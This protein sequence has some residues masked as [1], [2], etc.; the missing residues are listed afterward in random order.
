MQSCF[1]FCFYFSDK[2]EHTPREV[3][4]ASVLGLVRGE[5]TL[6]HQPGQEAE[7]ACTSVAS[8]PTPLCPLHHC[9]FP[10]SPEVTTTLT[11]SPQDSFCQFWIFIKMFWT[12]SSFYVCLVSLT[13][14]RSWYSSLL[15]PIAAAPPFF[16]FNW[17]IID[18]QYCVSFRCTTKWFIYIIYFFR[19]FSI[20]GLTKYWL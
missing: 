7:P 9:P 11:S 20:I 14:F 18:L 5:C 13:L 17:S 1:L 15:L 10:S 6:G 8:P 16:F 12:W 2:V 4:K 3:H 19:L